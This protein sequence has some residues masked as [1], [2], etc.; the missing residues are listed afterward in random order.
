MTLNLNCLSPSNEE[1]FSI[2]IGLLVAKIPLSEFI[3]SKSTVS[4]TTFSLIFSTAIPLIL[5]AGTSISNGFVEFLAL[6][7]TIVSPLSTM[8]LMFEIS[9]ESTSKLFL[10][11]TNI[12][13]PPADLIA[14]AL[15]PIIVKFLFMIIF[16]MFSQLQLLKS[17]M[18][19]SSALSMIF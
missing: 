2:L 17:I 3:M 13:F 8:N 11:T 10:S 19:P 16:E 7:K 6:T 18:S 14:V 1:T 9:N 4:P 15:F 5:I 12:G